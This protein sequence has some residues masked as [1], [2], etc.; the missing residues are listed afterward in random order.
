MVGKFMDY[1]KAVRKGSREATL[2]DEH[3][4]KSVNKVF[5]NKKNYSR[6]KKHKGSRVTNE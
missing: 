3:G 1:I 6:K 4:W 5:A 2:D